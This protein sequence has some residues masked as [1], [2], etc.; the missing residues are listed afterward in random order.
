LHYA[1]LERILSNLIIFL[2]GSY[3]KNISISHD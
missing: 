2:D 1:V 3:Q